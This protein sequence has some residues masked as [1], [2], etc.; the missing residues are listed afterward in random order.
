MAF[1]SAFSVIFTAYLQ[2]RIAAEGEH[3]RVMC[4]FFKE[5]MLR[6]SSAFNLTDIP[7]EGMNKQPLSDSLSGFRGSCYRS[8][9]SLRYFLSQLF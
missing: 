1:L 6:F 8:H 9:I 4:Y 2:E 5:S 3:Y 7:V